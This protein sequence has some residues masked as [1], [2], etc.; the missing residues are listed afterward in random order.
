MDIEALALYR[1]AVPLSALIIALFSGWTATRTA[2][3]E[4]RCMLWFQSACFLS[5]SATFLV[6]GHGFEIGFAHTIIKE[7]VAAAASITCALLSYFY[8]IRT[9]H[10]DLNI[11]VA[12]FMVVCTYGQAAEFPMSFHLI[13]ISYIT[14]SYLSTLYWIVH[15]DVM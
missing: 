8:Y 2:S 7:S 4:Q 11:P 13:A 9:D 6:M 15:S 1:M 14:L 5:L 3:A 12:M 10:L